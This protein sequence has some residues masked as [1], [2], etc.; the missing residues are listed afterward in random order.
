MNTRIALVVGAGTG[1]GQATAV[2]LHGA[3]YAVIAVDRNE[4][5][6]KELPDGVH[7]EVADVTDL[8]VPTPLLDR[9]A[10]EIG[11]PQVL[12][13]TIGTFAFGSAMSTTPELL[14]ELISVNV[15]TAL[16]L[17]QAVVPHMKRAG[18]GAIIHVAARPGIEPAADFAAYGV[19][20]AALIHL[21]RTLD[22]EL[23]PQG[24][25]VNAIAPQIIATAKNKAL[26]P[27]DALADAVEPDAIADVIAFLVSDAADP[28]NGAI[29]PTY[30]H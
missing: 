22:A 28:I 4:S 3:G 27:P 21:T 26:F 29:V 1:L 11:T 7:R 24:I 18:K 17:T 14:T 25:R 9:I 30:G 20:K 13:N 15:G 5:G 23:R 2:K 10:V 16:W 12:V 19:S 6:L 8:S